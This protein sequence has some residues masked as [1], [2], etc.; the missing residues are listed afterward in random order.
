MVSTEQFTSWVEDQDVADVLIPAIYDGTSDKFEI[1][2]LDTDDLMTALLMSGLPQN[3]RVT[4]ELLTPQNWLALLTLHFPEKFD[5]LPQAPAWQ[6]GGLTFT[7]PSTTDGIG[8][9]TSLG[10]A[11]S[12]DAHRPE[13]MDLDP[14]VSITSVDPV[15]AEKFLGVVR[16]G[17]L[18]T[19][20]GLYPIDSNGAKLRYLLRID[21]VGPRLYVDQ[22]LGAQD[23]A[24][25]GGLGIVQYPTL[26]SH[27]QIDGQIACA[28]DVIVAAGKVTF[29]D[30][31]SGTYQPTGKNL[32]AVLKFA[33]TLGI[34]TDRTEFEQFVS[35]PNGKVD[36]GLSVL[37]NR[38]AV[39][40]RLNAEF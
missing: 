40:E 2:K 23:A 33:K 37:L 4:G 38:A 25:A 21:D 10:E 31:H 26:S 24:T 16:D 7:S 11:L 19:H 12:G 32:G 17:C 13:Q 29:I 34:L 9:T 39:W 5:K 14:H 22:C 8:G 3:Q 18:H 20:D 6:Q 1:G 15:D 36:K 28:G 30:N 35:Q 27:A